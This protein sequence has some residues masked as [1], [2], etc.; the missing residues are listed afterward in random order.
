MRTRVMVY[1]HSIRHWMESATM[2]EL[3]IVQEVWM[4]LIVGCSTMMELVIVLEAWMVL[5]IRNST[6]RELAI[7]MGL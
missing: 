4:V 1:L 2:M 6:R 5:I 7:G 3:V